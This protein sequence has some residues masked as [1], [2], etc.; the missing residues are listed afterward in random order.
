ML[1]N[2]EGRNFHNARIKAAARLGCRDQRCFPDIAEIDSAL[3]EYQLLFKNDSQ[4]ETL[5]QLRRQAVEAMQQLQLFSPRLTGSVLSG[6]AD[7]QSP[8]QLY[9]F[10]DTPEE[11]VIYLL[12]NRIPFEQ[13]E[14]RMKHS[15]GEIKA[16]P[17]FAFEAGNTEFEL[18]LLS[19][20]DRANP[21]IDSSS[22][23]PGLG[24]SLS[25][26]MALLSA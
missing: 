6:T 12:E 9:L 2:Q 24:A 26:A 23:K 19:P 14:I 10:A 17:L 13:E 16:H 21:P 22:E 1:A 4:P 8:V 18:I 20:T 11:L 25:Q 15:G 5:E 7:T 3:R